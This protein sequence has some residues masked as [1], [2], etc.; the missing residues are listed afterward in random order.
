EY[1]SLDSEALVGL[2]ELAQWKPIEKPLLEFFRKQKAD[3]Y[4]ADL[5]GL[6]TTFGS[7]ASLGDPPRAVRRQVCK[8]MLEEVTTMLKRWEQRR[9]SSASKEFVGTVGPLVRGMC[10]VGTTSDVSELIDRIANKPE[11]YDLH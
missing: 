5:R 2:A 6:V 7:L 3:D 8:A 4:R 10:F 9:A 1:S 11:H